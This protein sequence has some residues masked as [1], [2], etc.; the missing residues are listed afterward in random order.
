M[1]NL[2]AKFEVSSFNRSG[3]ME[4][5]Q[6]F[7]SRS[8]GPFTTPVDLILHFFRV[9]PPGA[10]VHDKFE[11]SIFNYSRDMEGVAKF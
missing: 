1:A 11:V 8:R 7:K 2:H 9:G 3:D 4:E 10:N 6:N 5:S